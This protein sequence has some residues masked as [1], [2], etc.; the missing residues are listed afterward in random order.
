M[1]STD[2]LKHEHEI[3]MLILDAAKREVRLMRASGKV[4]AD[5]LGQMIDFFRMFVDRCHHAKEEKHLFRLMRKRD[6]AKAN[7]PIT[8]LLREH[9]EGRVRVKAMTRALAK[10]VK[11]D[12][13][14]AAS[15]AEDLGAYILLLGNHTDKEDDVVYPLADE[16]L[17]AADQEALVKAFE[18]VER[19]EIGDGVHEKYHQLAHELAKH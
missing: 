13:R 11:G 3:L 9:E 1:T 7:G 10:A 6:A 16:I 12:A 19:R 8:I 14:A 5:R 2:I 4:R 17:K 18:A 15:L